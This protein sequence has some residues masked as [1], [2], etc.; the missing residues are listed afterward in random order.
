MTRADDRTLELTVGDNSLFTLELF[1]DADAAE[2]LSA[3]T[4]AR[5]VVDSKP[6]SGS[7]LLDLDTTAELTLNT[8]TNTVDAQMT[9]VQADALVPGKYISQLNVEFGAGNWKNSDPFYTVVQ[10]AV[11]DN[12]P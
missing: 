8:S 11:A 4:R 12:L 3:A 2:D 6:G 1:N 5:L 9:S 7:P 10:P